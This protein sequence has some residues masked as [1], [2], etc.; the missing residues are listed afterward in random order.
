[1]SSLTNQIIANIKKTADNFNTSSY[2]NSENVVC[3]DSSENRIGINTKFP[4][5]AIHISGDTI[6][7][8]VFTRDIYAR[9]LVRTED[10]SCNNIESIDISTNTFYTNTGLFDELSGTLILTDKV[11]AND[12]SIAQ[13]FCED[14]STIKLDVSNI[15][16]AYDVNIRNTLTT[17]TINANNFN[18]T[19]ITLDS[20]LINNDASVNGNIFVNSISAE[21][22]SVQEI[23]TN[24]LFVE[25]RAD[26]LNETNFKYL[27][28]TS[29]ASF[30]TL[31]SQLSV[32]NTISSE[33]IN[34]NTIS[35]NSINVTNITSGNNTIVS[36]GVFGDTINPSS[37]FF[38]DISAVNI[39]VS[40]LD[41]SGLLVN[42]G[43]T[44]LSDGEL[45]LPK[46]EDGVTTPIIGSI[47]L[48]TLQNIMKIYS[49]NT[50]NN[51]NF[52][53][54][55]A[56]YNLDRSIP[57]NTVLYNTFLNT[58]SIDNSENL[59]LTTDTN[60]QYNIYKYVPMN[61]LY[62]TNKFNVDNNG[63]TLTINTPLFSEIFEITATIVVRYLNR[64]PGDVEPNTYKFGL[65]PDSNST[66]S[67][68]DTI[69]NSF[70]EVRNSII[71]FDNSFNYSQSTI[72]YIGPFG[73]S[74]NILL[75][76]G[77]SFYVST[78]KDLKYLNID[79]LNVTI[80]QLI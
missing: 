29:E 3:I 30:N 48:D 38:R 66:Q 80:K 23:S 33:I 7:D 54:N 12:I 58:F 24:I 31:F 5:Y 25:D 61:L 21:L 51:L 39:D 68:I 56:M 72:N 62:G 20:L 75:R 69:D 8:S 14:I 26:F 6:Q 16:N 42:R 60:S 27:N 64:I 50:W 37:A 49:N 70:V 47:A 78:N 71:T 18:F 15:L 59:F 53:T 36:N 17:D 4:E 11:S 40:S 28:V 46:Y 9:N 34:F 32:T 41:V 52:F 45:I 1:M 76:N 19:Q 22:I 43:L 44:D 74:Q 77:F 79:S 55:Y 57:G 73:S 2:I 65:Y 67:I 10:L 35:G 63:K 13:F